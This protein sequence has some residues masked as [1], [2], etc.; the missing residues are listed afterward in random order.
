M[1]GKDAEH[2]LRD[3]RGSPRARPVSDDGRGGA[4]PG[5]AV[6]TMQDERRPGS[7]DPAAAVERAFREERAAV[8]AT[9]IRH[10]GDFQLA[11]D[12]VQDAFAAAVATWPRDG[13]PANPGAWLTTAARRKAID[14]LRRNRSVADRA[15]RLAELTRTEAGED[16]D[17][18][19][20][21]DDSAIGD[22]RLR[23]IFT[24]CHPALALPARV[25]LTLRM[26]GG[27]TT[28]EV[29]RAFL[30]SEPTMGKRIVR[31]KRKIAD[32][33]IPYRVPPAHELPDRPQGLLRVVH[34]VFN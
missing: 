18:D 28:T 4:G 17:T 30:V 24:C 25:A 12:A 10:V 2:P 27:L 23:L 31:A 32:A 1:G 3:H 14:R 5:P 7:D 22:D 8:L 34:P 6:V 26:L 9:L 19:M 21:D 15:E 20:D 16:P 11:E 33:H 13:V 29:A